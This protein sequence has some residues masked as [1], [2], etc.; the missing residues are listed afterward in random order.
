MRQ[1]CPV[2]CLLT[3]GVFAAL[4]GSSQTAFAQTAVSLDGSDDYVSLPS[5][6]I[7]DSNLT[8]AMW[9]KPLS[10]SSPAKPN[11]GLAFWGVQ[12]G[13]SPS[14]QFLLTSSP[15]VSNDK[16]S[17]FTGCGEGLALVGATTLS[18]GAW[19]HVALT[20]DS[21]GNAVLYFNG[22]QEVA[23]NA[24]GGILVST[25]NDLIGAYWAGGVISSASHFDGAIDELQIYNRV[26]S[27]SEIS[28][29]FNAGQGHCG[30]VAGGGLLA[31]YH[32]DE[33]SGTSA[34]DFSG[35]GN[36]GALVNDAGWVPS[37]VALGCAGPATCPDDVLQ[38]GIVPIITALQTHTQNPAISADG[39][40]KLNKGIADLKRAQAMSAA[41]SVSASLTSIQSSIR[42][43]D[44]LTLNGLNLLALEIDAA[45]IMQAR[46]QTTIEDVGAYVGANHTRLV[47][48]NSLMSTGQ[49]QL[50]ANNPVGAA[51]SFKSAHN[52]VLLAPPH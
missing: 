43:M 6:T 28:E 52:Q 30:A 34:A 7:P 22:V 13:C 1:R 44:F 21:V 27:P 2:L 49:T 18:I 26:L 25:G 38:A 40:K 16:L 29:L 37:P 17:L 32:F 23:G 11:P 10:L 39:I 45:K 33:G 9:V 14:A 41:G 36:T 19:Q 15:S 35:N 3:L 42:N 20:I 51:T 46:V 31:G 4:Y 5:G 8:I 12:N 48:A 47:S 24:R 50:N